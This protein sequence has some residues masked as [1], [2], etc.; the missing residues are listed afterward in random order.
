MSVIDGIKAVGG[1]LGNGNKPLTI[2]TLILV[3]TIAGVTLMVS[4][5]VN[6]K[7]EAVAEQIRATQQQIRDSSSDAAVQRATQAGINTLIL[8][9]LTKHDEEIRAWQS[10][11]RAQ[12]PTK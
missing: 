2:Q 3:G 11:R 4:G 5:S 1:A 9:R 12:D 7:V 6:G 8:E 10:W